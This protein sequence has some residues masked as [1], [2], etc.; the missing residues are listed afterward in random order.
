[1]TFQTS[2]F[3][4]SLGDPAAEHARKRDDEFFA[5]HPGQTWRVRPLFEGESILAD[6]MRGQGFRAYAIVIDH[7]RA[8]DRRAKAGRGIYPVIIHDDKHEARWRLAQEG[9]RWAKWFRKHSTTPPPARGTG[10]VVG[11]R[12]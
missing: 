2:P 3:L 8:A 12:E 11:G 5:R 7:A 6:G 10:V 1:M 4:Y 9:L